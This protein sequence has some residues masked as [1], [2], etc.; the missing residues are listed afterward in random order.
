M[1]LQIQN[2]VPTLRIHSLTTISLLAQRHKPELPP[3]QTLPIMVGECVLATLYKDAT[4]RP[5]SA[6]PVASHVPV[7]SG[8][9]N[10]NALANIADDA[11]MVGPDAGVRGTRIPQPWRCS[12]NRPLI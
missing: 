6:Y 10:S 2:P 9:H 7:A 11:S 4:D 1:L 12:G 5:G 3:L 8:E